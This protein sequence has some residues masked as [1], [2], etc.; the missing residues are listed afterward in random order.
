MSGDEDKKDEFDRQ[1]R[2]RASESEST[3]LAR[4]EA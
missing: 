4:D 2:A 1:K 3:R